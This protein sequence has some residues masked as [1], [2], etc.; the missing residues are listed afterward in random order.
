MNYTPAQRAAIE[1]RD[2]S[3]FLSAA[4]GSGKTAVLTARVIAALTDEHKPTSLSRLLAVTFTEAATVE[5]R[6]RIGRALAEKLREGGDSAALSRELRLLPVADISTIDAFCHKILRRYGT[7]IVPDGFRVTDA[8]EAEG[9]RADLME[10][11]LEAGYAGRIPDLTA[12]EFSRLSDAVTG[13]NGERSLGEVLL[14]LYEKL[15]T[16]EGGV[17]SLDTYADRYLA[18][19]DKPVFET[20]F[21]RLLAARVRDG[22]APIVKNLLTMF[23]TDVYPLESAFDSTL[24]DILRAWTPALRELAAPS[25]YEAM[26]RAALYPAPKC[27]QKESSKKW[28]AYLKEEDGLKSA[29]KEFRTALEETFG[30]KP[31]PAA[32]PPLLAYGEED[33]HRL[34][35]DLAETL[36]GLS[37]TLGYFDRRYFEECRRRRAFDFTTL[38]R[39]TYRLLVDEAGNPTD[40]AREIADRYDMVAVDEYQDVSPLQNAVFAAVSRPDNR[41]FVGDIKQ[42]I[43]RFRH[44]EPDIFA[45]LRND[46]PRLPYDPESG[47]PHPGDAPAYAH[48]MGE[49]FRCDREVVNFVNRVFDFLFGTAGASIGYAGETDALAFGKGDAQA[50]VFPV[51]QVVCFASE[52]ERADAADGERTAGGESIAVDAAKDGL[53]PAAEV[54][55]AGAVSD[56]E[57]KALL[58]G[59]ASG[60]PDAEGAPTEGDAG[61]DLPTREALYVAREIRRLLDEETHTDG[62]TPLRPRDIAILS[63]SLRGKLTPFVRALALYGVPV[64]LPEEE[65]FFESP[66]ILLAVALLTVIDNPLLD[67]PLAGVLCSP[68]CRMTPDT[69]TEIRRE[70]DPDIP[71]F[72]ALRAYCAAHP[73]FTAG[74][75]FLTLLASFR[76]EAEDTSVAH[77][78]RRIYAETTLYS[79]AGADGRPAERNLKLLY[80]YACTFAGAAYEGLHGFLAYIQRQS[81]SDTKFKSPGGSAPEDAVRIL[82]VHASKG[83]EFPVVFLVN[84]GSG[85]SAADETGTFLCDH[86]LGVTLRL[87]DRTGQVQLENPVHTLMKLTLRDKGREEEMRLLYVALTRARERLYITGS[88][89]GNTRLSGGTAEKRVTGAV[90]YRSRTRTLACGSYL[91]WLMAAAKLYPSEIPCTVNGEEIAPPPPLTAPDMTAPEG[92]EAEIAR[93]TEQLRRQF[94]LTEAVTH[95]PR[96]PKKLAVSS[97]TPRLLDGT[98]AEETPLARM[99]PAADGETPETDTPRDAESIDD[100]DAP[101]KADDGAD[102]MTGAAADTDNTVS[103]AV[104]ADPHEKY[105]RL[106]LAY[107][108]DREP[109]PTERGIATHQFL[110][111]CD[112]AK[113]ARDGVDAEMRRL[114]AGAFLTEAQ[115]ALT[116]PEE[117]EAFRASDLFAEMRAARE[118]KREFRF[119]MFLPAADFTTD[120]EEKRRLEGE[121][122]FIQGVMDALIIA[123]DGS[124]TLVDYK[125]DRLTRAERKNPALARE[126]LL[127]RHSEQMRYYAEAAKRIFGVAPKRVLLYSLHAG[128]SFDATPA[129][130]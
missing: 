105:R 81:E 33:W 36:R 29:V 103:V 18:E 91:E 88:A 75:T 122:L 34:Y 17:A 124:L 43:Y 8:A 35:R 59:N 80:H 28:S 24:P 70:S 74:H 51:P 121:T 69:L 50:A 48:F 16:Y 86:A 90:R 109:D 111:F 7:H 10:K 22:M 128:R 89:A 117:L 126:K 41:F 68:L 42:S 53:P 1:C 73:D 71:L 63:R 95:I 87:R 44:A 65:N 98:E 30:G 84:A 60:D 104:G 9:Y 78:V 96:L 119:H 56:A 110:Q 102:T 66:E 67:I 2:R 26:R 6:S 54:L 112:F 45:A 72:E 83:L 101:R 94:A 27:T 32:L 106:P 62:K 118:V 64:A 49:N 120:P 61:D 99:T 107:T 100:E 5:M 97:L 14:G 76:R 12:D 46:Y 114:V 21:G 57:T 127:R 92:K 125:T 82:S 77:L 11:T 130:K 52:K 115:A 39:A 85:F 3:V 38:T 31:N 40:V 113:L 13:F 47:A 55:R 37:R 19:A 58:E 20:S 93:L 15:S 23:E 108:G 116:R 79:L 4:A 123:P 129:T 25:D